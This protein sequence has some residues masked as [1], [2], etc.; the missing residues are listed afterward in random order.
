MF[1]S[2]KELRQL[3]I[4]NPDLPLAIFATEDANGGEYYSVSTEVL[5]ARIT[6]LALY[7]TKLENQLF[8]H[9]ESLFLERD[10][11]EDRLRDDLCDEEEYANLSDEEFDKVVE[12]K[13]S[14]IEFTKCIYVCV[15]N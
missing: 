8:E 10:D 6:E 11:Y 13:L 3:I 5:W 14:E 2:T 15:G 12:K 1:D 4:D 7:E 9:W